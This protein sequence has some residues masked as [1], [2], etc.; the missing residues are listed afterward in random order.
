MDE[1][2]L[3]VLHLYCL[4]KVNQEKHHTILGSQEVYLHAFS[5]RIF[6]LVA[7]LLSPLMRAVTMAVASWGVSV[8]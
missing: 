1:L 5:T 3:I 4:Y 6:L 7:S 8:L 2:F